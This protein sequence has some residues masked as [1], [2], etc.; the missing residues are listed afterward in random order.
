MLALHGHGGTCDVVFDATSIYRGLADH[1]ARG[2]YAVLAPSFPHR[3]YC[4]TNLWD[5]LRCV[6]VLQSRPEV[7]RERLGVAGLS[8]GGEWTMWSAACDPRLKGW[9][10]VA[11]C[12]RRRESSPCRTAPAGNCLASC[13]D[14]CEVHLL[15]ALRPLLFERPNTMAAFRSRTRGKDSRR[16]GRPATA[17]SVRKVTCTRTS[18]P[19]VT[20]GTANRRT[21]SL[22]KR[23]AAMRRS[24]SDSVLSQ[25]TGVS[26]M[27]RVSVSATAV[28][29]S[30]S[31]SLLLASGR[32]QHRRRKN[33]TCRGPCP[34]P[35]M[36]HSVV[37]SGRPTN[38]VSQDCHSIPT[39]R[40]CTSVRT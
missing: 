30:M 7:D 19:P 35:T 26:V 18:G 38:R 24:E 22:T 2:G 20:S 28:I 5:L 17:C 14:V 32:P 6:D 34:T 37:H 36:W 39:D 1:F 15:I 21:R 9:S 23:W 25:D 3:E 31:M 11:G 27:T 4:A 33:C 8:M 13:M 12:V 16:A 40:S 29:Y 10:S